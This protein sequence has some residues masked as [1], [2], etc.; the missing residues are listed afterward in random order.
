M[1]KIIGVLSCLFVVAFIAGC[2]TSNE[3]EVEESSSYNLD[4]AFEKAKQQ[5]ADEESPEPDFEDVS[6]NSMDSNV[7][8]SIGQS[9]PLK[10][11]S[12]D[13]I[14]VKIDSVEKDAGD[15]DYYVPENGYYAKVTFTVTNL[16]DNPFEVTAHQLD[17]YDGDN[18]KGELNSRDFYS[19]T[20][21]GGKSATGVAYFDIKNDTPNY[22]VYFADASWT[23]SY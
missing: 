11:E 12:G 18:M 8:A 21:Q 22:E 1:K 6:D 4:D 13:M 5:V 20:I 9:Q 2:S 15:G 14:D 3:A 10:S 19:E 16:G 7:S 17:F 23:G